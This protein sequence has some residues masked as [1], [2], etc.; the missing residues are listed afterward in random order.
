MATC[1]L[2]IFLP[3]GSRL[4]RE[5]NAVVCRVCTWELGSALGP[6][7]LVLES[8]NILEG[9][10]PMKLKQRSCLMFYLLKKICISFETAKQNC[11]W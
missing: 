4:A 6:P 11:L 8:S 9:Q 3:K 7:D 2:L 10:E 5:L 1:V